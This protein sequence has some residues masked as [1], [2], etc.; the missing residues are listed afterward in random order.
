MQSYLI[1]S[2]FDNLSLVL[3]KIDIFTYIYLS[4]YTGNMKKVLDFL[5]INLKRNSKEKNHNFPQ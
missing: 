5:K 4:Y 1:E 2:T 3:A